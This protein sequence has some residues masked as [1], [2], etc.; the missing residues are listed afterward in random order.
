MKIDLW[1]KNSDK[2][3]SELEALLATEQ[4]SNLKTRKFHRNV[5]SKRFRG[6]HM[7]FEELYNASFAR[8]DEIAERIRIL[9]SYTKGTFKEY[10]ELSL[11]KEEE[12]EKISDVEMLQEVAKD[13]VII[14]SKLREAIDL[15]SEN[16][17]IWTE[18]LLTGFLETYE[19]DLWMLRSMDI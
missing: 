2:I 8:M 11:V 14:I 13:K 3:I 5:E 12:R 10:L 6:I 9:G 18:S 19:K 17:D 7:Y 1:I 15:A 16:G 4:V